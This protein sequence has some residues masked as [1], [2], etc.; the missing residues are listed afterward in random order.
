METAQVPHGSVVPSC[1]HACLG[2]QFNSTQVVILIHLFRHLAM[3]ITPSYFQVLQQSSSRRLCQ[4][5]HP[6]SRQLIFIPIFWLLTRDLLML[7]WKA[8]NL[9]LEWILSLVRCVSC[10]LCCHTPAPPILPRYCR[11]ISLLFHMAQIWGKS[12]SVKRW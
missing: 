11:H 1:L 4:A 3:A 9:K 6:V 2:H 7:L 8:L 10:V 5:N 12:L